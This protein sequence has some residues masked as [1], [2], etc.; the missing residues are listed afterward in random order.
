MSIKQLKDG[1]YYRWTGPKRRLYFWNHNG[2]MN[3]ILDGKPRKFIQWDTT[4]NYGYFEGCPIRCWFWVVTSAF[5]D[6]AFFEEV[7]MLSYK[8]KTL[9]K[10]LH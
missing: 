6:L 4:V 9:K 10:L 8:I 5:E 7:P 2:G 3:D 1:H